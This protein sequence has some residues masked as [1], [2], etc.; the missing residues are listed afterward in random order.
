MIEHFVN[1]L[2]RLDLQIGPVLTYNYSIFML[3]VLVFDGLSPNQAGVR[4]PSS[5]GLG[6]TGFAW[7]PLAFAASLIA[8]WFARPTIEPRSVPS[9]R[10]RLQPDLQAPRRQSIENVIWR[11][12]SVC[13]LPLLQVQPFYGLPPALHSLVQCLLR[14]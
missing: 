10:N 8:A 11:H 2:P 5:A 3:L 7:L 13:I 12:R 4:L 14:G 9:T 1:M 6:T